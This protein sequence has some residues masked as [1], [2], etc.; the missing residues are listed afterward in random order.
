MRLVIPYDGHEHL[1]LGYLAA[2]ARVRGHEV[3]M[4]P[5]IRGDYIRGRRRETK[6][7]IERAVAAVRAAR[8]DLVLLSINSFQ[9]QEY[10]S[11]GA[12][13]RHLGIRA[14]AGGP[15]PTAEPVVTLEEGKFDG[16]IRGEADAVFLDA[17]EYLTHHHGVQP[18]WLATGLSEG[19]WAPVPGNLDELPFPAKDLFF[20]HAPYAARD[21]TIITARGCP[22]RCAYCAHSANSPFS[23]VR[24]RGVGNC[25]DELRQATR[26]FSPSSIYFLDDVFTYERDRLKDLLEA[27]K[28]HIR[29]PFHA[30][31]HPAFVS[32][33][34]AELLAQSGCRAVRLGVQSLTPRVKRM[35]G[36]SESNEQVAR[37]LDALRRRG[38]RVEADH[39]VNIPGA[40]IEEA[41]QEIRFYN[42]HRPN[43]IKVYWLVP[44]PGTRW[45]LRACREGL[46]SSDEAEAMRRGKGFGEHSYL[47]SAS[48]DRN[49]HHWQGIHVLLSYLPFLPRRVVGW[50]L[51]VQVDRFVRIPSFVVAVG[52]PRM[53]SI[54]SGG[55]M[56]GKAHLRRLW[57]RFGFPPKLRTQQAVK[58]IP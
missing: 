27:Y 32:E 18:E 56:V 10:F 16:V 34:T 25:I 9:A 41:R 26:R 47:F 20:E 31:T 51:D 33:E 37:A 52:I 58:G 1:G 39:M 23:H 22:F 28:R 5:V 19:S 11:L 46:I 30:I 7:G 4:L 44:L 17:V 12:R 38:I 14:L 35:M 57:S 55:D 21:Y 40:S 36:R 13:L 24:Y 8:P 53:L 3:R 15:H 45:F 6:N 29:L 43:G 49:Q 42:T 2:A 54:M 48:R 50:L